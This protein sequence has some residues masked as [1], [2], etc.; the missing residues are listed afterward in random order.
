MIYISLLSRCPALAENCIFSP[1]QIT[2]DD[3]VEIVQARNV[4][5]AHIC[6]EIVGT[7]FCSSV[8]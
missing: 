7:F 3:P 8:W 6:V 2:T 1:L 5:I 4:T